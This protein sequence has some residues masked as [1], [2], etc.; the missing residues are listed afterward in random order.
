MLSQEPRPKVSMATAMIEDS[1]A[2]V[3]GEGAEVVYDAEHFF[4]GYKKNPQYALDCIRTA[5][6]EGARWIGHVL[7]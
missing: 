2:Y 7:F 1:L 4:D 3:K 6:D 5:Y